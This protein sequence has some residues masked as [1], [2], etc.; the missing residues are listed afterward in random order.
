M[1]QIAALMHHPEHAKRPYLTLALDGVAL[2][3]W[4]YAQT[5]CDYYWG[6]APALSWLEN[7]AEE[8][9][10]WQRILP[11]AGCTSLAPVLVCPDDQHFGCT[12]VVAEV[13]HEGERVVWRRLGLDRSPCEQPDDIGSQVEWFEGVEPLVFAKA[14][15]LACLERFGWLRLNK[16]VSLD[17]LNGESLAL[18]LV[19]PRLPE[20]TWTLVKGTVRFGMR[21]LVVEQPDGG[22]FEIQREWLERI[23]PVDPDL[24]PVFGG[25]H[26]YLSLRMGLLAPSL[27][28]GRADGVLGE[29]PGENFCEGQE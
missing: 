11:L 13:V 24:A 17:E 15:Y 10:A 28:S 19:T 18:V 25:A 4:I 3:E 5:G 20:D 7:K 27:P 21:G 6:L 16:E 12:T 22:V 14:D 2:D 9:V 1:K 8:S 29:Y 26:Y 23:K